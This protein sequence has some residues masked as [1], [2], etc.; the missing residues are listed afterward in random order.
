MDGAVGAEGKRW[1]RRLR[2]WMD[3]GDGAEVGLRGFHREAR[4]EENGPTARRWWVRRS[5][6]EAGKELVVCHLEKHED[7]ARWRDAGGEVT[8]QH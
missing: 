6:D 8:P 1:G 5:G 3:G 4:G 2:G 7:W